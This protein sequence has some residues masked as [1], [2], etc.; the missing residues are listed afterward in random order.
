[1]KIS[2]ESPDSEVTSY[3]VLYSCTE[4]GERE[5]HPPPR[6]D[7]ETAVLR[8]LLPGTEYTVKVIALHGQ[9][10]SPALVSRQATGA[11]PSFLTTCMHGRG[12]RGAE[13]FLPF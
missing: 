1:M 9:N 6:A 12:L 3:R 8:G 11:P 7:E 13:L 10:R 5:V 2:W 4:E